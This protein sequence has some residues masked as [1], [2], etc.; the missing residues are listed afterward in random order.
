VAENNGRETVI[1]KAS[2]RPP[3]MLQVNRESREEGMKVYIM[4]KLDRRVYCQQKG[5]IYYNPEADILYF[6]H[7]TTY[8]R[9]LSGI[10]ITGLTIPRIAIDIECPK[11]FSRSLGG[12]R[13]IRSATA[14]QG[15][16]E[17][18][19]NHTMENLYG[20]NTDKYLGCI[21]LRDVFWVET[22]TL[23]PE[24]RA[25]DE[26]V[27]LRTLDPVESVGRSTEEMDLVRKYAE[28][29]ECTGQHHLSKL[30]L[31]PASTKVY[32]QLFLHIEP[33]IQDRVCDAIEK[34]SKSSGCDVSLSCAGNSDSGLRVLKFVGRPESVEL[35]MQTYADERAR[36]NEKSKQSSFKLQWGEIGQ[37]QKRRYSYYEEDDDSDGEEDDE[38]DDGEGAGA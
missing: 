10:F 30:C 36:F 4:A 19:V 23:D 27:G 37:V 9:T 11:D 21:G 15:E 18:R 25:I 20:G 1:A 24:F 29:N 2:R 12:F 8:I 22:N 33:Y 31:N 34:V 26:T 35:A 13:R 6:R 16:E 28:A 3:S 32:Q 7:R 14:S 38:A 5:W 17:I